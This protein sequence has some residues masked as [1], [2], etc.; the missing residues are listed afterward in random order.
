MHDLLGLFLVVYVDDL[1]LA[2]PTGNLSK[3]WG[4]IRQKARSEDPVAHGKYLGCT[5]VETQ[6]SF[7]NSAPEFMPFTCRIPV[8]ARPNSKVPPASVRGDSAGDGSSPLQQ[9]SHAPNAGQKGRRNVR[10]LEYDMSSFL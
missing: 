9:G 8:E 3:G 1:K 2:G 7:D 6:R 5:H 4:L 10:C